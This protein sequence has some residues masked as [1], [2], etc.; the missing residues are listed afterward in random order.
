MLSMSLQSKGMIVFNVTIATCLHFADFVKLPVMT[1][2]YYI[3]SYILYSWSNEAAYIC[4]CLP[5]WQRD[6][7]QPLVHEHVFGRVH[8]PPFR[9]DCVQTAEVIEVYDDMCRSNALLIT[10]ISMKVFSVINKH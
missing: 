9:Q 10:I 2:V 3:Q 4:F 5:C 7:T 1:L 8:F 6:P